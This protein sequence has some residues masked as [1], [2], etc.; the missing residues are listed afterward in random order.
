MA[1]S[2]VLTVGVKTEED[3]GTTFGRGALATQSL[4][5]AIAVNLVV[6]QDTHLDLLPLVLDLLGCRVV[7]LLPLLGSSAETKDEVK[8]RLLL[9]V[10]VR[11]RTTVLE[12]LSSKDQALLV[13]RNALL[14]LD[15]GLDIVDRVR[16]LD[17]EGDGLACRDNNADQSVI[18]TYPRRTP[19][20]PLTR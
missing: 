14:V 10:V 20:D 4:D 7:L 12:L 5:L 11:E 8:G 16:A 18:A 19:P 6:A 13:R 9:D 15:L 2:T 17:L 1:L 3:A